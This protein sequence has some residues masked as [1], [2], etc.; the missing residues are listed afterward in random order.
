[1]DLSQPAGKRK[2]T[3]SERAEM[4]EALS[5]GRPLFVEVTEIVS[6]DTIA[7]VLVLGAFGAPAD[8]KV[9]V[10][11]AYTHSHIDSLTRHIKG[12]DYM[13]PLRRG[14]IVCFDR[15]FIENGDAIVANITSRTHDG[16][17]G[18]VQ[19]AMC[20][21]RA[22]TTNVS[23]RGAQQ[24]LTIVDGNN[25]VTAF[26]GEEV[27]KAYEYV[28]S[29]EWASGAGG[30]IVRTSGGL[31]FEYHVAK[32]NPLAALIEDLEAREVFANKGWVE[33]IPARKF[34]VGE[35]QVRRD[36]PDLNK[37]SGKVYGVVGR[38]Y[39]ADKARFPGFRP[40]GV[41]LCDEE[42]WAFGGKTGKIHRVAGG[43]QPLKQYVPVDAR[44]LPT[45]VR[46]NIG[47][48]DTTGVAGLYSTETMARMAAERDALRPAE[49]RGK[50]SASQPR[51]RS[52]DRDD[53][54]DYRSGPDDASRPAHNA[55][56]FRF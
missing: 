51:Q 44:N 55:V 3:E 19:F 7:G 38:Q 45:R 35:A 33:L 56:P 20:M 39:F 10:K 34:P 47:L 50:T 1:M 30:F 40:T 41:I 15:A 25:A 52:Y 8:A 42:E 28:K 5:K 43:I 17:R 46:P 36:V 18:N 22:S 2:I 26:A 24:S 4:Q 37:A 49:E 21:A 9:H 12:S 29:L 16:M 48:R 53:D 54:R 6:E 11:Q 23:K 13:S 14:D 27:A 31:T 32:D